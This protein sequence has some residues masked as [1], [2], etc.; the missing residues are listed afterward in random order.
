MI[1]MSTS[2]DKILFYEL[3]LLAKDVSNKEP[4]FQQIACLGEEEAE[5]IAICHWFISLNQDKQVNDFL[6]TFI[7]PFFRRVGMV[8][9]KRNEITEMGLKLGS[10]RRI[11]KLAPL[12]SRKVEKPPE[13]E[14]EEESDYEP[15][16]SSI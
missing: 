6:K 14:E 16:D 7:I 4:F 5:F 8:H 9:W 11:T 2:L 10:S 3:R 15:T 12:L 1:E 13:G